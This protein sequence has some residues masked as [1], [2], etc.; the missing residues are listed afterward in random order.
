M[1]QHSDSLR[2]Q[3]PPRWEDAL[4]VRNHSAFFR[5][6]RIRNV[7]KSQSCMVL[8]W[9]SPRWEDAL[10][11]R[12]HSACFSVK[13]PMHQNVPSSPHTVR[14]CRPCMTDIYLHI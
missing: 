3:Q 2:A 7:G 5:N 6:A 10:S 11:V 8:C 13:I 4:S 14:E 9:H 12:N 1:R